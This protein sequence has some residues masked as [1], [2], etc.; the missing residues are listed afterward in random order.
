MILT[1]S[2]LPMQPIPKS[3]REREGSKFESKPAQLF[4]NNKKTKQARA[5]A[6]CWSLHTLL[7]KRTHTT[8]A[9]R[10]CPRLTQS[11]CPQPRTGPWGATRGGGGSA[12]PLAPS[13]GREAALPQPPPRR[14]RAAPLLPL[15]LTYL[16][17]CWRG[18]GEERNR[19]SPDAFS[20]QKIS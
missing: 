17:C 7:F 20:P 19:L 9:T 2:L 8:P 13:S 10:S 1:S 11:P 16:C 3:K 6:P 12:P 14:C 4:F 18:R 15:S 5:P